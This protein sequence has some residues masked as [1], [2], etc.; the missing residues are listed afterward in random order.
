MK[1]AITGSTG[2]IGREL[3]SQLYNTYENAEFVLIKR[4]DDNKNIIPRVRI[5]KFD[6]LSITADSARAFFEDEKID[7]FFHLAWDTNHASYLISEENILWEQSTINLINSFYNSGGQKFIGIGSSI[8]Y[9][10]KCT[11]P[12]NELNSKLNGNNWAYG[13]S[14]L[15][16]FNYLTKIPNISFQWHRIFFVFGP[17]QSNKRL[18]P[19][20]INNALNNS[21]PLSVNLNLGRDYISTFEIA[22]QISMMST[23]SYIGAV[24]VCSGKPTLISDIISKIEKITQKNIIISSNEFKDNFELQNISGYQSIIKL[25][26]PD[27]NYSEINFENDLKKTIKSFY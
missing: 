11:N 14:K 16:I 22:K 12:F 26:F 2:I 17:G 21:E 20:I 1:I 25:Y 8:E 23:T 3:F 6:L 13:K 4:N 27:Y 15:N 18:I 7:Y 10:W 5:A 19:L 9:D 24:N